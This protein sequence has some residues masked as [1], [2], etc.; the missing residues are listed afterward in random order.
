MRGKAS[1]GLD[2]QECARGATSALPTWVMD[3]PGG[4]NQQKLRSDGRVGTRL[5]L[6]S[7]SS[8]ILDTQ[9]QSVCKELRQSRSTDRL[10]GF[11]DVVRHAYKL[12]HPGIS[13][14]EPVRRVGIVISRLAHA[15]DIDEIPSFVLHPVD[16]P[17]F[18]D[19]H[20]H[21]SVPDETDIGGECAEVLLGCAKGENISP[22]VRLK[23][24]GVCKCTGILHRSERK[25]TEE[26]L[27]TCGDLFPGPE[28]RFHAVHIEIFKRCLQQQAAVM[29]PL[30][31]HSAPLANERD[32][33][34]RVGAI[35]YGVAEA[36]N[37]VSAGCFNI[38]ED[39]FKRRQVA[40]NVR[41]DCESHGQ[42]TINHF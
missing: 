8:R 14:V 40:V 21:V 12:V 23:G 15:A 18:A 32:A 31:R 6:F 3:I 29:I 16:R 2:A 9:R 42:A 28:D 19:D 7:T 25:V 30:Q 20:R 17:I 1:L 24:G 35:P 26:R 37:I 22:D 10:H 41:Y 11:L 5:L 38:L 33:F 39:S 36:V 27:V 34:V 4:K 13:V